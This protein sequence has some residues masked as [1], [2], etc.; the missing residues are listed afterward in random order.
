MAIDWWFDNSNF[1]RALHEIGSG[2]DSIA[3]IALRD[4]EWGRTCLS[5]LERFAPFCSAHVGASDP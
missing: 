4:V 1:P 2:N 3:L 5:T